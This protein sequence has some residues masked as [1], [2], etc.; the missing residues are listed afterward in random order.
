MLQITVPPKEYWNTIR[1]EFVYTKEQSL[2]LEH[3][4]VSISKWESKWHKPFLYT[5]EKSFT[6]EEFLY[7]VQCM[8]LTQNVDPNIYFSLTSELINKI[9]DYINDPMTATKFND[10]GYSKPSRELITSELIYY[11][12]TE[13][14][15]PFECQK[16]HL[17]RLLTLIHVCNVKKSP[18]KKRSAREIS[19]SY[20]EENEKRK[21]MWNTSG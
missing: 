10:K 18:V 21:K 5:L 16:W 19:A 12:M 6:N 8:T 14:N 1:N 15:I 13:M 2:C 4:L 7:Y 9:F 20:R 11:W 3:S 17:N